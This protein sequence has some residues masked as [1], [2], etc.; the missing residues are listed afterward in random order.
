MYYVW[1]DCALKLSDLS[2][3]KCL[4]SEHLKHTFLASLSHVSFTLT[5]VSIFPTTLSLSLSL[6]QL[7][8]LITPCLS[9]SLLASPPLTIF[10]FYLLCTYAFMQCEPDCHKGKRVRKVMCR[11]MPGNKLF[12]DSECEVTAQKP[13]TTELCVNRGPCYLIPQ[14][15]HGDWS[16]VRSCLV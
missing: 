12:P 6:I 9:S 15:G 8:S 7:L 16:K 5:V 13:P 3:A 10:L 11:E 1:N 14:W 4:C 2:L